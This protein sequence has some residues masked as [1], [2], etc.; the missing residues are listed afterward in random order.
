MK[1]LII[2]GSVLVLVLGFTVA[3]G[4]AVQ[5]TWY[6]LLSAENS[7]GT[8]NGNVNCGTKPGASDTFTT[9]GGEDGFQ[10]YGSGARGCITS[11]IQPLTNL[12]NIDRRAPLVAN[13]VKTWNLHAWLLDR[14][15]AAKIAGHITIYT[16]LVGADL[17]GK[18][19]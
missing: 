13:Q 18:S 14:S 5:D 3:A 4:A 12:V 10:S 17:D 6:I 1:K 9:G 16:Y 8:G 2:I 11:D 7:S 19:W 15:G